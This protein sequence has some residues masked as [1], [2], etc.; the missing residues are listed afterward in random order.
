MKKSRSADPRALFP[1]DGCGLTT[2][3]LYNGYERT[4]GTPLITDEGGLRQAIVRVLS[5]DTVRLGGREAKFLRLELDLT[6]HTLAHLVGTEPSEVSAWER[7][8]VAIDHSCEMLLRLLALEHAGSPVANCREFLMNYCASLSRHLRVV[9][10]Q[11]RFEH[12]REGWRKVT[13]T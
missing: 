11:H 13:D 3:Y 10:T 8:T 6:E 2:I 9:S 12:S 7:G 1:Y 5:T 4:K